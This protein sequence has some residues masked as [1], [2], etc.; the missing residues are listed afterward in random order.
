[1][2]L[3]NQSSRKPDKLSQSSSKP[4][5]LSQS[6]MGGTLDIREVLRESMNQ[7]SRE[8]ESP[9]RGDNPQK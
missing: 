7:P 3:T 4:D 1:M 8:L 2:H 5:K 9:E 6:S